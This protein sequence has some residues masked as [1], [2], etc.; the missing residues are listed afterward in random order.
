MI[1]YVFL[2]F[3]IG[4]NIVV[5]MMINGKLS[6]KEGMIN[7]VV[8]N[9]LM[10]TLSSVILCTFMISSIPSYKLIRSVPLPYFIGGFIGVLT[11]YIFN[12]LVPKVPAV[13]VVIL[14]FIGQMFA[15]AIIDYIYLDV[16]SK[17]K[18][19]GGVLFLIGLILNARADTKLNDVIAITNG[20]HF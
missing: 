11:T 3:L 6:Q 10:A 4:I 13:Y 8:I 2:A 20:T 12:V 9:Y 18:V 15:S 5:N 17:G 14:R 16:F 1:L 7:G 19:I